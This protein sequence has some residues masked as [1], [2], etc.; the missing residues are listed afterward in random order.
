MDTYNLEFKFNLAHIYETIG[1]KT[2]AVK[3]YEESL[4]WDEQNLMAQQMLRELTG[5]KRG[6]RFLGTLNKGDSFF[7]SLFKKR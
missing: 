1:S 3:T 2:N 7:G 5:K 4:K 6:G